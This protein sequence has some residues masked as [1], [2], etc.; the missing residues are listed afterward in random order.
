MHCDTGVGRSGLFVALIAFVGEINSGKG[1]PDLMAL[2]KLM[3]ESYKNLI[4]NKEHLLLISQLGLCF[5]QSIL[6]KC[7][8]M[9][10]LKRSEIFYNMYV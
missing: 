5:I 10:M 2:L 9:L 1:I 4:K 3:S 8:F 7:K 6:V